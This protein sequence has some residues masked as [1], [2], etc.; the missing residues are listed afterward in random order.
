[1]LRVQLGMA[2]DE[3]D[4][5]CPSSVSGR[6]LVNLSANKPNLHPVVCPFKLDD[7]FHE[8]GCD[9]TSD[10]LVGSSLAIG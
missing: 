7:R 6:G 1:M 8:T 4:F 5:L 2:R 3:A 9:G 10:F